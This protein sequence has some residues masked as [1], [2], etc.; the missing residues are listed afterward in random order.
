MTLRNGRT[1]SEGAWRCAPSCQCLLG[2]SPRIPILA[3]Q[4]RAK[5]RCAFKSTDTRIMSLSPTIC[6]VLPIKD[7]GSRRLPA[8]VGSTS[9]IT[10]GINKM[11][12]LQWIPRAPFRAGQRATSKATMC[13][14][15]NGY[16]NY[17]PVPKAEPMLIADRRGG[18]S[19]SRQGIVSSARPSALT[20]AGMSNKKSCLRKCD[21][22]IKDWEAPLPEWRP[23][24]AASERRCPR[25]SQIDRPDGL[26]DGDH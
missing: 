5:P 12:L 11:D 14:G 2:G 7:S 17:G 15:M 6:G 24:G 1:S 20:K 8:V 16:E 26:H 23:R 4:L 25:P 21:R 3:I 18:R 10:C 13:P 19:N 9:M 22:A